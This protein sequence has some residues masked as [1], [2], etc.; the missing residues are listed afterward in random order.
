MSRRSSAVDLLTAWALAMLA[1]GLVP[2]LWSQHGWAGVGHRML[3]WALPVAL[4]MGVEE[5]ARLRRAR[6]A[7]RKRLD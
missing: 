2:W 4:L 3:H 5:L 7:R 1:L 6:R